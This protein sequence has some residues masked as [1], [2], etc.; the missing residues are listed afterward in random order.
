[1][2]P[3]SSNP[4]NFIMATCRLLRHLRSGYRSSAQTQAFTLAPSSMK[5]QATHS[6]I[7]N[8]SR[9]PNIE[10]F[11]HI[12]LSMSLGGFSKVFAST[13]APTPVS[14]SRNW[15]S[16][17]DASIRMAVLFA[18]IVLKGTNHTGLSSLWAAIALTTLG[19][20]ARSLP[21]SPQQNFFS[22]PLYL[23]PVHCSTASTLPISI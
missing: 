23:L 18:I 9:S 19:T 17:K 4:T 13:R 2:S 1:M 20:R 6:S 8:S 16:Q 5:I 15:M 12:A 22:T 14:S 11:G 3:L 7:A 10:T 21:I